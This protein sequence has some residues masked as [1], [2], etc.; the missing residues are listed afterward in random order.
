VCSRTAQEVEFDSSSPVSTH[1]EQHVAVAVSAVV[2]PLEAFQQFYKVVAGALPA[3]RQL[4]NDDVAGL[5]QAAEQG[6]SASTLD[7]QLYCALG[8]VVSIAK[9][10]TATCCCRSVAARPFVHM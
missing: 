3:A 9:A 8:G 1:S 4:S 5:L 6:G 2:G 10:F 7:V